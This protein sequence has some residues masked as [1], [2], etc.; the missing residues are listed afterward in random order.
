MVTCSRCQVVLPANQADFSADG[1]V[2]QQCEVDGEVKAKFGLK[3]NL[4][5]HALEV[6][7]AQALRRQV[8]RRDILFGAVTLALGVPLTALM[9]WSVTGG[10]ISVVSL[11]PI[12]LIVGGVGAIGRGLAGRA[13]ANRM[14]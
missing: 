8:A 5:S 1:M 14:H 9:Y 11:S 10:S 13:A 6:G 2:C 4:S 7:A 12:L 3:G